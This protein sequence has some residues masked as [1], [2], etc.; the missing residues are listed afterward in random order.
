MSI[1]AATNRPSSDEP[2]ESVSLGSVVAA[3]S[4]HLRAE[5]IGTGALAELRRISDDNLP[6]AFWK[7]Y[8]TDVPAQWREPGGQVDAR[9]DRA[10]AGLIRGMVEMAPNPHSFELPFGATLAETDYSEQRFVRLLRA[11][12]DDL[13][14]EVRIAGAWLARAG[15]GAVNWEQPAHLLLGRPWLGLHV[16]HTITSR[17]MARDYFGAAAK[18]S[19][20]Q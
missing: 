7:R 19:P 17:R 20:R 5:T 9:I 18:Q 6:P 14:R 2:I 11:E 13:A 1:E 8:L 12:G 10:W 16:R 3:L 4:R 15:T